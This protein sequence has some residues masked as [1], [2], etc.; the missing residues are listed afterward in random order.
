MKEKF[1]KIVLNNWLFIL[2]VLILQ[3]KSMLLLSMLRTTNSSSINFSTMYFGVPAIGAH[4]V[5]ITLI[6]S[7]MFLF[8][9]KG[10][11]WTALIINVIIT[12]LFIA[13]IWYYR[14]NGT[15]LSIRH[16][17]HPEIFNPIGKNLIN[18]R[19]VDLLFV[20]DFIV[21]FILFKFDK[22]RKY[23]DNSR[24][25]LRILKTAIVFSLSALI[26]FISHYIIDIKGTIPGQSFLR[27]SWAP[28]QTFSDM[29]PLGYHGF[30][31]KY[32]V[33][34]N[35]ELSDSDINDVQSWINNNK[36]DIPDNEYFGMLKGK[37]LIAIQVES[38]E[39]FVINKKVYGQEIT[40]T[41][42]KLLSGSLYFDNIYE[43]NNSG[44]SSDCDLMVNTS[45]F[46]I[47]ATSTFPTYPW[48]KYN[49]LQNILN[50]EG[51]T[52]ISTHAELPGSWN[53]AEPHK[54]FGADKLWDINEFN[55]D[56]VIGPGLSDE[57]YL[58]QIANKIKSENQPFYTFIAT[59]TSHGPFEMPE[60]K[61]L[62][63]LPKELDDNMLGGYFQSVRYADEAIKLFIEELEKNGQLDNTVL[64]IYGDHGGVHKFYEEEI[65][66]APLN[67]NW[68]QENDKKI[69]FIIY[70]KDLKATTISKAG[71]QVDFLP[72]ISYLLGVE[73]S[74]FD[75]TSMGRVLVNTNRNATIL[76]NGDIMGTPKD[77][78]E[79]KH[80]KDVFKIADDII[81]GNYFKVIDK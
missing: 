6:L 44:T 61:K 51:Y 45:I 23:N 17:L 55:I 70:N 42:N 19:P 28:F 41:L 38:L 22:L 24:L 53:W 69:P 25:S 71:G 50:N 80:L 48:T 20:I 37:N 12:I 49:S 2:M 64:M 52:T 30:D 73:R 40:P 5:I 78:N 39:N 76:N 29:S 68:W 62:L 13:D 1:K 46:P 14:N 36:E 10:K 77:E 75:N 33:G 66:D 79:E 43:Q 4:L 32:F 21:F 81:E 11:M 9:Y 54:S 18:F 58:K 7:I 16:L 59:L 65:K 3:A 47:R 8:K 34:R 35:K 57:S 15:F 60:D 26:I 63:N 67:E 74:K 27:L 56:E 72:T 31:L